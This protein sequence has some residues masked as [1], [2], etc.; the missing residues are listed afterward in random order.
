MNEARI[1]LR[2]RNNVLYRAIFDKY[3]NVHAFCVAHGVR[4]QQVGLLLNLKALPKKKD[5]GYT[6][7]AKRLSEIC[8]LP[9]EMLFPQQ[10]YELEKVEAA[11]GIPMEVLV[12]EERA[13]LEDPYNAALRNDV[14]N[15]LRTLMD[16]IPKREKD[17]L[18]M[19]FGIGGPPMSLTQVG[20]VYDLTR[21][22]I[23][24]IERRALR[25]LRETLRGR[26]LGDSL[27]ELREVM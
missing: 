24:Q 21:E 10:L 7:M 2:I 19:R 17:V 12:R 1:E 9:E 6:K 26:I 27:D 13:L 14:S 3:A 20:N 25:R 4:D 23:R 16:V 8:S 5:G 22:R 15:Q 11:V 18:L